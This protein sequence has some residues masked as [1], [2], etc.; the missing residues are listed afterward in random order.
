MTLVEAMYLKIPVLTTDAQGNREI[1]RKWIECNHGS[2]WQDSKNL[3]K[4]LKCFFEIRVLR[5]KSSGHNWVRNN[6]S[7]DKNF[8]RIFEL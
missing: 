8:D 5:E 3:L 1:I 7:R 6:F 2:I 4:Q